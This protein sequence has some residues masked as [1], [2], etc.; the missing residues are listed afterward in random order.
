MFKTTGV[1]VIVDN[2]NNNNNNN[3]NKKKKKKQEKKARQSPRVSPEES[4]V[5][6]LVLI[7]GHLSFQNLNLL[8]FRV[9][10]LNGLLSRV[11]QGLLHLLKF[12][13]NLGQSD[14][15]LSGMKKKTRT[16]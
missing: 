1:S 14:L 11:T 16:K 7:N 2:H 3:N 6:I 9:N 15:E 12:L 10:H 8:G 5:G 4:K 13:A